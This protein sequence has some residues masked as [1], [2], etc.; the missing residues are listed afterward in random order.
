MIIDDKNNLY[1]VGGNLTSISKYSIEKEKWSKINGVLTI[2]RFH[3]ILYIRGNVLYVFFGNNMF[4]GFI[5]SVEKG[6]LTGKGDF[7]IINDSGNYNLVHSTIIPSDKDSI[8][9]IG[10][11][12]NK[13][14]SIKYNFTTNEFSNSPLILSDNASFHQTIM[15]KLNEGVFGYFCLED[16]FSF[17]KLSFQ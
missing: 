11:K 6:N 4:D 5:N 1:V 12:G 17:I 7:T 3:P 10:G 13:K 8:F 14:E 15:P 2:N 9:I 16:G